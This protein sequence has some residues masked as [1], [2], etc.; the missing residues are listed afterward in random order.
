MLLSLASA[1]GMWIV[2]RGDELR[3]TSCGLQAS[4][5]RAPNVLGRGSRELV[6]GRATG[7]LSAIPCSL[8]GKQ[9]LP[10]PSPPIDLRC[11][12]LPV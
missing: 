11:N 7:A 4:A 8:R 1:C 5:K 3:A 6:Q 2:A 10:S 12:S 9:L